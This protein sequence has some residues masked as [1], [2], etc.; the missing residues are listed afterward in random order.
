MS[1]LRQRFAKWISNDVYAFSSDGS[2]S[3]VEQLD[4]YN[5]YYIAIYSES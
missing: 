4:L 5:L 3:R 2:I 1:G